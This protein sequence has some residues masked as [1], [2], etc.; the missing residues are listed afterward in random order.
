MPDPE[1]PTSK[2]KSPDQCWTVDRMGRL[3]AGSSILMYIG[4]WMLLPSSL[5][6]VPGALLILAGLQLVA[7]A[8]IGWCP[9]NKTLRWIGAKEREE[10]FLEQIRNEISSNEL[11]NHSKGPSPKRNR[12]LS[13]Q[14]AHRNRAQTDLLKAASAP[15]TVKPGLK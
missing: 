14:E 4:L 3:L 10:V 12:C 1:R 8:L 15:A 9:L 2:I 13:R 5:R 6:W 11:L 7:T